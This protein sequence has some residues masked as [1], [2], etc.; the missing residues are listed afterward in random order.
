MISSSGTASYGISG[1]RAADFNGIFVY[2][3]EGFRLVHDT[4]KGVWW[5]E[6]DVKNDL[7]VPITIQP[8]VQLYGCD[9]SRA[10]TGTAFY[11]GA[12]QGCPARG[13]SVN[14]GSS[15][16]SVQPSAADGTHDSTLVS[17]SF[18]VSTQTLPRASTATNNM[19]KIGGSV[20][21]KFL[22]SNPEAAKIRPAAN[23]VQLRK[24]VCSVNG[25]IGTVMGTTTTL[26]P[27]ESATISSTVNS[28]DWGFACSAVNHALINYNVQAGGSTYQAYKT[29][30]L[31]VFGS[32]ESNI[33]GS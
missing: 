31:I 12:S 32:E 4:N 29:S 6:W 10:H 28:N 19:P 11:A 17:L 23:P 21:D 5:F 3:T 24:L 13:A 27:G 7:T 1:F 33:C 8:T 26:Q 9:L 2:E 16:T 20:Y 30:N 22:K 15:L 18:Q 25:L 14:T